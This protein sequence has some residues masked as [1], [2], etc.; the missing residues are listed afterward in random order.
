MLC[1]SLCFIHRFPPSHTSLPPPQERRL[2]TVIREAHDAPIVA[3]HFFPG[4]PL[5]MSSGADNA[6]RQ[7]VLDNSDGTARLLRFRA[8]HAAPPTCIKHYGAEG[9][10]LLSGGFDRAFRVFSTIQDQQSREISQK[11]TQR[12]AKKLKIKEE[13]LKLPPLVAMDASELRER[14]WSNAVT[15]HDNDPCAYTWKLKDFT[16]GEHVLRPPRVKADTTPDAPV[17]AVSVTSCGN[18]ALVGSAAGRVDRYNLQSGLHRGA[19]S[20][21]AASTTGRRKEDKQLRDLAEGMFTKVAREDPATN[22]HRGVVTGIA[23]DAFNRY[24]VTA[25]SDGFLRV[26]NFRERTLKREI[27]LG[28]GGVTHLSLHRGG[29]LVAAACED[30]SIKVV[31]ILAGRIVRRF[32]GHADRIT[33]LQVSGDGQWVLSSSMDGT[34]TTWDIPSATCLQVAKLGASAPIAAFSLAPNDQML[35]TCHVGRRGIYLWANQKVFGNP[36]AIL[37]STTPVDCR[38]PDAGCGLS[39]K[40]LRVHDD[41]DSEDED[42]VEVDGLAEE[43]QDLGPSLPSIECDPAVTPTPLTPDLITFSLLPKNNWHSLA[44]LALIKARNKPVEG[45]KKDGPQAPFFLSTIP[46]LAR[47]PQFD[48]GG[49]VEEEAARARE[50]EEQERSR[51]KRVADSIPL[52]GWGIEGESG[53][54]EEEEEANGGDLPSGSDAEAEAEGADGSDEEDEDDEDDEEGPSRGPASKI[55]KLGRASGAPPGGITANADT[56]ASPFLRLLFKGG[57]ARD[58]ASFVGLL[59]KMAPTQL[60]AEI[61][62]LE[63]FAETASEDDLAPLEALMDFFEHELSAHRNYEF[64]HALLRVFLEVHGEVVAATP[65]LALRAER[66]HARV[67]G[68]W[69]RL[70]GMLNQAR[71]LVAHLGNLQP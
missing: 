69:L 54:E 61:R 17:T 66:L 25:A 12:R 28:G 13:E 30:L 14:D 7:F 33:H 71:A 65:S 49:F 27:P 41:S 45:P 29:S 6:L 59:R 11:N 67:R 38:L 52:P 36:A 5:L 24:L 58:Y 9:L 10:R 2:H 34:L 1:G 18:Y 4:E 37:P 48:V 21:A 20:A 53:D 50:A 26:W 35:A 19:Y 62:A 44:H 22:A 64:V 68:G 70:E 8:G 47:N 32:A 15:A 63:T 60:D 3:L 57:E 31:D 23:A 39:G 56:D 51:K 16:L 46:S 42:P 43:G 40:A 55:R